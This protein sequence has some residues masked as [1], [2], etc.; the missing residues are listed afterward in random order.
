MVDGRN[1]IE[2]LKQGEL[3]NAECLIIKMCFK[4]FF[5]LLVSV[6]V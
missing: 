4:F 3:V 2:R 6:I 5:K 1:T